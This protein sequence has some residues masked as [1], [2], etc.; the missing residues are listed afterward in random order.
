MVF[1]RLGRFIPLAAKDVYSK[2]LNFD[3]DVKSEQSK[4]VNQTILHYKASK[5]IH[6][7]LLFSLQGAKGYQI[8]RNLVN[9][10]TRQFTFERPLGISGV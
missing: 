4:V 8:Y 3:A 10:R 9:T 2:V 5:Q 6:I 1:L 7:M